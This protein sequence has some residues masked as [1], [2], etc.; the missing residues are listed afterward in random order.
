MTFLFLLWIWEN[1]YT[2]L[3]KYQHLPLL[4]NYVYTL[5]SILLSRLR[6]SSCAKEHTSP[7]PTTSTVKLRKK[8]TISIDLW[9]REKQST[10]GVTRGLRSSSNK[11]AY[12]NDKK[13]HWKLWLSSY[14]YMKLIYRG[15]LNHELTCCTFLF[16]IKYKK[17]EISSYNVGIVRLINM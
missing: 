16:N 17:T 13:V 4:H 15:K 9:R 10:I 6:T 7:T 2:I 3:K 5:S 8:S 14:W 11:Y 1:I 12:N